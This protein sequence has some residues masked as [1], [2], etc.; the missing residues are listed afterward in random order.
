MRLRIRIYVAWFPYCP[1]YPLI[2]LGH[3]SFFAWIL[4]NFASEM[5]KEVLIK[6]NPLAPVLT[7]LC[8]VIARP[9]FESLHGTVKCL[10]PNNFVKSIC[11]RECTLP[12][13]EATFSRNPRFPAHYRCI[14][15]HSVPSLDQRVLR[16]PWY[17]A[18]WAWYKLGSSVQSRH[19]WNT[20]HLYDP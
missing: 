7:R 14:T 13:G 2:G 11:W 15:K 19:S 12:R 1:S 3:T 4:R 8:V 18:S 9:F 16:S 5:A 10:L 6:E 20:W 17:L